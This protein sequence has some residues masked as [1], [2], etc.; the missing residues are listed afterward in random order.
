LFPGI[1]VPPDFIRPHL[2]LAPELW[3][4]LLLINAQWFISR[5][6]REAM[7]LPPEAAQ[8][9]P[10]ELETTSDELREKDY[11][12]LSWLNMERDVINPERSDCEWQEARWGYP[13]EV[14][15]DAAGEAIREIKTDRTMVIREDFRPRFDLF[16]PFEISSRIC[17]T[18]AL[19]QR[20]RASGCVGVSFSAFGVRFGV[21]H[22]L[23][24]ED[25]LR[26]DRPGIVA[27]DLGPPASVKQA[28]A[29][30]SAGVT[31]HQD[32]DHA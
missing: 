22:W 3:S 17:A 6:L 1:K 14:F 18:L 24:D 16:S 30:R 12:W 32:R 2:F 5:P 31:D 23:S 9:H 7:R 20:V 10:I 4:D 8:F 25:G 27:D 11:R 15:R 28:R 21:P 26:I 19:E 29:R 13:G